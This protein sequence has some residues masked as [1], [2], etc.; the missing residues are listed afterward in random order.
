[1][2]VTNHQTMSVEALPQSTPTGRMG[3]PGHAATGA[4]IETFKYD[5]GIVRA[6]A[7]ATVIWAVVG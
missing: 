4:Q 2:P 5:N 3:R 6:F 1:M 7:I